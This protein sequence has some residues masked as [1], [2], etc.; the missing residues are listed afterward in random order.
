MVAFATLP[1]NEASALL[2]LK[3]VIWLKATSVY[4]FEIVLYVGTFA[5]IVDQLWK[6]SISQALSPSFARWWDAIFVALGLTGFFASFGNK[7]FKEWWMMPCCLCAGYL[8]W[9]FLFWRRARWRRN[10]MKEC[11]AQI[12]HAA[13]GGGGGREAAARQLTTEP[14]LTP[15]IK[16]WSDLP[17]PLAKLVA[18]YLVPPR[19]LSL[20]RDDWTCIL[21][22]P[23][24]ETGSFIVPNYT[25]SPL[26]FKP[27]GYPRVEV[28]FPEQ[29]PP[30]GSIQLEPRFG[31]GS[32]PQL[33]FP[34]VAIY[35][36]HGG[37]P[38][39]MVRFIVD[40]KHVIARNREQ[41][42]KEDGERSVAESIRIARNLFALASWQI[43]FSYSCFAS[44]VPVIP[45][46][47]FLLN[48][49]HSIGWTLAQFE[50]HAINH[51]TFAINVQLP[52]IAPRPI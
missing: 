48:T 15:T 39:S 42:E 5:H 13:F 26:W 3:T 19:I 31:T 30:V 29:V 40:V 1:I 45:P 17:S 34:I 51:G 28:G 36:D 21:D 32:M 2:L 25:A 6:A 24:R 47:P 9:L 20:D 18:S 10:V 22:L 33:S 14:E 4:F 35:S 11:R 46:E 27:L 7:E 43:P 23:T 50:S 16:R 49:F 52:V 12:G 41:D 37:R 8:E 38:S 44:V